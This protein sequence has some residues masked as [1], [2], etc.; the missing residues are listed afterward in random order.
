M[1]SL[2]SLSD[3]LIQFQLL[4]CQSSVFEDLETFRLLHTVL[5][6]IVSREREH[7]VRISEQTC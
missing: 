4:I 7:Y 3:H 1:S 5:S 2:T 6:C